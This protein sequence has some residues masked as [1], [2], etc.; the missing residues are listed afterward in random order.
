MRARDPVGPENDK[1][2]IGAATDADIVIAGWG[3][4]RPE[5]KPRAEAVLKILRQSGI[6]LQCFRVTAG[7]FPQHPLY[8]P[9]DLQP[10]LYRRKK[11]K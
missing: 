11:R 8:L 6:K 5:Y 4:E 10:I 7:G 3:V 9:G 1:Y 2:I